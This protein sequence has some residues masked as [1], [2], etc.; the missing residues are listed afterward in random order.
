MSQ[1]HLTKEQ[2]KERIDILCQ[3]G[4]FDDEL[5]NLMD[6]LDKL[7]LEE[8][9]TSIG[10]THLD[11]SVDDED[12]SN[13]KG[14]QELQLLRDY[15]IK[16]SQQGQEI[17]SVSQFI[18]RGTELGLQHGEIK[19]TLLK[20]IEQTRERYDCYILPQTSWYKGH[21]SYSAWDWIQEDNLVF[22]REP[23]LINVD[24]LPVDGMYYETEQVKLPYDE[25]L[26]MWT[27]MG[28]RFVCQ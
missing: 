8:S 27:R 25:F 1:Q 22:S 26:A 7:E 15:D 10:Y 13:D 23:L 5:L 17:I 9:M 12:D 3:E 18:Q 20:L 11:D 2:I 4:A 21:Q 6:K 24:D 16:L 28:C 14:S 19:Q